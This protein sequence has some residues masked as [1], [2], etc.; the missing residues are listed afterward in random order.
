MWVSRSQGV[1]SGGI[2]PVLK[3]G[4][5]ERHDLWFK[6]NCVQ[7]TNGAGSPLVGGRR[8]PVVCGWVMAALD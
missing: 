3:G 8:L 5:G 2:F 4:L 1:S 7:E 6:V